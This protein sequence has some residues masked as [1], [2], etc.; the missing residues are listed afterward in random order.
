MP[1]GLVGKVF[2]GKAIKAGLL[3]P[4]T[5]KQLALEAEALAQ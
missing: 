4:V 3:A 1:L 5:V 2:L